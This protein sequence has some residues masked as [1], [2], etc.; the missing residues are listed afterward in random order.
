MQ[1]CRAA[2]T[3]REARRIGSAAGGCLQEWRG[4]EFSGTRNLRCMHDAPQSYCAGKKA[5]S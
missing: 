5:L 2:L 3:A 4:G 1:Q